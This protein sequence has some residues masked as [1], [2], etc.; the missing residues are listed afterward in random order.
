VEHISLSEKCS[1]N[2]NV[3]SMYLFI[4]LLR[5]PLLSPEGEEGSIVNWLLFIGY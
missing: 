5:P 3:L 2:F 4:M 1:V